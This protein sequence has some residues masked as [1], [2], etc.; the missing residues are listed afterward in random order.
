MTQSR[1]IQGAVL[2][3]MLGLGAPHATPFAQSA[4][5]SGTGAYEKAAD[6][7]K[8]P[9]NVS[10]E[11]CS[12][13][14]ACT[15][16][17]IGILPDG[18]GNV[19]IFARVASPIIKLD[20]EGRLVKSFGDGLFV[21]PHG[22][23]M[24]KEGNLWAGDGG[25]SA[26]NAPPKGAQFHKFTQDGKLLMSLGQAGVSK[27]GTD[28][29]LGPTACVVAPNGD[30]IIADG[31]I[32]RATSEGEGDRLVRFSKDGKYLQ[33]YGK[34]GSGPGEFRGPHALAFDS[35]GRL[36][37]ADRSNSRIQILDKNMKFAAEWR[38]FGRP[39]AMVILPDDTL[40]T[41]DWETGGP[42]AWPDQPG[43]PSVRSGVTTGIRNASF[44]GQVRSRTFGVDT[45]LVRV[46]RA[47]DGSITASFEA[48][49]SEAI[50]ADLR[51]AV[52]TGP[53]KYVARL[54]SK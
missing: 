54:G 22:F 43:E 41:S 13:E 35:K 23:C 52:Y 26:P 36:F 38:Q 51:G 21:N 40:V 8:L 27:V 46:G 42:V 31:H 15:T 2:A 34:T 32:P 18:S 39:S 11:T 14:G 37:V 19:W 16:P 5:A 45:T 17:V 44:K 29:F 6:W 25:L 50:G 53:G 9:A 12:K 33:T 28:T 4:P 48:P 24:D 1:C 3:A 49:R 7:P 30:I 20:A 47:R 10:F